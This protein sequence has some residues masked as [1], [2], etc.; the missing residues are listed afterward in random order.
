MTAVF[1]KGNMATNPE[2]VDGAIGVLLDSIDECAV[3]AE[4]LT[5][6]AKYF[7]VGVWG[8]TAAGFRIVSKWL[9][10]RIEDGC[11]VDATE[12][13]EPTPTVYEQIMSALGLKA[14][15]NHE[16]ND[17]YYTKS[18]IDNMAITGNPGTGG[19]VAVETDPTVPSWAKQP[20]KPTYTASEV[21]ALPNSTKIPSAT[22]D[23]IN[24]SGFI[25]KETSELVNYYT[26]SEVYT[27]TEIDDKGFIT[28]EDLPEG[29]GGIL[30]ETDPTVP[31]WA[32]QAEKPAYDASEI[33]Y[34]NEIF[35]NTQTIGDGLDEAIG[36]VATE[37][38]RL[39]RKI[40]DIDIP[41]KVSELYNDSEYIT[42][43]TLQEEVNTVLKT[44]KESGEFDGTDGNDGLSAYQIWLNA[45]NTGTELD[46][47]ES[48]KGKDGED[49]T[50]VTHE[51][52]GTVLTVTS[53]NGTSS[54]DLKGE[55]GK[56][57]VYVGTD[58][59][60][61]DCNVKINP[62]G[63]VIRV[64]T[65]LSELDN[66]KGFITKADIPTNGTSDCISPYYEGTTV[67]AETD[68]EQ[69]VVD[70]YQNMMSECMGDSEKIPFLLQTDN[71]NYFP[72]SIYNLCAKMINFAQFSQ[73]L[74]LGDI[75]GNYFH[76]THL[77]NFVD[78]MKV[79]PIEKKTAIAGNH[80]VWVGAS[81]R[82][83]I[84]QSKLSKYLKNYTLRR[85]GTNGYGVLIDDYFNMKYL[86]I[87]NY[88]KDEG[89]SG[90]RI[91]TKQVDFI[92]DELSKRD[93]YD[94]VILS[95][96]PI[97][98]G[99]STTTAFLEAGIYTTMGNYFSFIP[100][101]NG[102]ISM[103]I[104]RKNKGSGTYTDDEGIE[105]AYDFTECN[106]DLLCCFCGHTH[107]EGFDFINGELLN[108]AFGGINH[109][110]GHPI[111]FGYID[112]KNR[113]LKY[114]RAAGDYSSSVTVGLDKV[115]AINMTLNK[116]EITMNVGELEVIS[117][118]FTPITAGN[119]RVV[120]TS[121]NNAVATVKKGFVSGVAEGT[122]T[123]TAVSEEGNFTA[124]CSV[125]VGTP[126]EPEIP[127][128][129]DIPD[130]PD[131]PIGG[132][133]N[134]GNLPNDSF[135][136]Y[137][138]PYTWTTGYPNASGTIIDNEYS[139]E[140]VTAEFLPIT[141]GS[142]IC[143]GNTDA[144]FNTKW[145]A[146]AFYTENQVF[147]ERQVSATYKDENGKYIVFT[148]PEGSAYMKVSATMPTA[149]TAVIY[150]N[151]V[152]VSVESITLN[153]TATI[154]VGKTQTLSA[155]VNPA[156]ATN[157][158]LEWTSSDNSIATVDQ[159]GVVTGVTIGDATITCSATDGSG[160]SASCL[161]T[162]E[163]TV[164]SN[165]PAEYQEVEYLYTNDRDMAHVP[166]VTSFAVGD[167]GY[168]TA[169]YTHTY[170]VDMAIC[171]A[172]GKAE[173]YINKT[174][175]F[176]HYANVV[177][178]N[179]IDGASVEANKVYNVE[180]DFTGVVSNLTLM[181]YNTTS[182]YGMHGRMYSAR[183]VRN[184]VDIYNFVPCYRKADGKIGMYDTVNNVFAEGVGEL[185]KGEDV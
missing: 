117:P 20:K 41:T 148:A 58:A 140:R 98:L 45:G 51:W 11:Y 111:Y 138:E 176:K 9:V 68:D 47:L 37:L 17:I 32:K 67:T 21:G 55:T 53:E 124:T 87:S 126:K 183:F 107:V 134:E 144:S 180:F 71:H 81:D 77:Q 169:E 90:S 13:I 99:D 166:T 22:S 44:A 72:K 162:V 34:T 135:T 89:E 38:P 184:G 70:A 15:I 172:Q 31:N 7:S 133:D 155:T 115:S 105:H 35:P 63:G 142:E 163:E 74:T 109:A 152:A 79:F 112:K 175:Q 88:D 158:A 36:Y 62:N 110:D 30:V 141:V 171:G 178:V 170:S 16:H 164:S 132:E 10:F 108:V 149:E 116:T 101:K 174:A 50:S 181:A 76:E 128:E 54:V 75:A 97:S 137:A 136:A 56:S 95:H 150:I 145:I 127:E 103:L 168:I 139:N 4:V 14:S 130:V 33:D 6:D 84:D 118:I 157:K 185:F 153:E 52:N 65:K 59:M 123:I 28:A 129:P 69:R 57:G 106:S 24:N 96:E 156:N 94:I 131:I 113:L 100:T 19:G 40:D 5:R 27:K 182:K 66:D 104:A 92:V 146:V 43:T 93:G 151:Q 125:T 173:I 78:A 83:Y 167:K 60:P 119:Q 114:Y 12:P 120:W 165:L 18:E 80:D 121:S 46:F 26:K 179:P 86:I 1:C 49:G 64:P 3:P 122:A 25:T 159:N 39:E 8:V 29:G 48:L 85:Y 23:L 154:K 82:S 147:I 91:S 161:V 143:L 102:F 160:A 2:I 61:L 42:E 73:F 177:L